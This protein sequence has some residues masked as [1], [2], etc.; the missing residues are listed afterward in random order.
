VR[1]ELSGERVRR[2]R[3]LVAL[4]GGLGAHQH[5]PAHVVPRDTVGLETR[6]A[7]ARHAM[8]LPVVPRARHVVAFERALA[9]RPADVVADARERAELAVATGQRERAM[10]YADGLHGALREL[11]RATD[12]D[13]LAVLHCNRLSAGLNQ[14]ELASID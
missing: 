1:L 6:L 5:T 4:G 13:P 10:A 14:G 11:R 2:V 12:V 7:L 3:E 8:E 9:E